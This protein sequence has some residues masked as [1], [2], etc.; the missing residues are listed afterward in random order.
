MPPQVLSGDATELTGHDLLRLLKRN[1]GDVGYAGDGL[2][3]GVVTGAVLDFLRNRLES[4]ASAVKDRRLGEVGDSLPQQSGA[5]DGPDT[6]NCV[7]QALES[8]RCGVRLV[9]F[10]RRTH[11]QEG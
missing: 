11:R 7:R 3:E 6:L 4:G 1:P 9:R 5:I 2:L 8:F 10:K